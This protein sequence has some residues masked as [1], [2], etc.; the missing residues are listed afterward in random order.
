M[1]EVPPLGFAWIPARGNAT[2]PKPRLRT[3]EGLI[4]RNE[5]LE[6]EIDPATG[7]LK[8][9]RDI[10]TRV[11]RVGQMLAYNPGSRCEASEIKVT[12]SGPALGEIVSEGVLLDAQNQVL[13]NFR[14]RFRAWVG[15]PL[16]D[17]RVEI[18]PV[19]RPT[20][21]P[22]HAYYAARF[23]WRDD[24]ATFFRGSNGVP[25]GHA[26]TP[27]RMSPDYRRGAGRPASTAVLPG[28]LPFHQRQG[29]RMLDVILVP[30]GEEGRVFDLGVG[31]TATIRPRAA[32]GYTSPAVVVPTAKGP[33]HVG[34]S[35][36]LFHLDAGNLLLTALRPC[37]EG[38]AVVG[39]FTETFAVEP[40]TAE[41]RCFRDPVRAMLLDAEGASA[42]GLTATGDAVRFDYA[43]GDLPRRPDRF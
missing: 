27:G 33:P 26:R 28:G 11:P 1:V 19:H 41:L 7:G 21:Y 10:R 22:W 16:L 32:Q 24:R 36:W 31:S 25:I 18:D 37:G 30:E 2:A 34:P 15:R 6:A 23:A 42:F 14:Q 13:A 43:A 3:A 35:G 8:V 5:Y 4:V 12:Q 38:R 20:G 40:G 39:R 29:T 17:I 9:V